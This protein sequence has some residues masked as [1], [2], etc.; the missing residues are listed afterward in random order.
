MSSIYNLINKLEAHLQKVVEIEKNIR[1]IV[2]GKLG[3]KGQPLI[4]PKEDA[5]NKLGNIIEGRNKEKLLNLQGTILSSL[6]FNNAGYN[7]WEFWQGAKENNEKIRL[8]EGIE[9]QREINTN[10]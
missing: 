9:I 4:Q 2:T 3:D 5:L 1:E 6:K 8:I 7:L 10:E